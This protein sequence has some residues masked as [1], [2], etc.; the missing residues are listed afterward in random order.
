VHPTDPAFRDVADQE[1]PPGKP[2]VPQE[3]DQLIG[4]TGGGLFWDR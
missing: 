4:R 1:R 3:R 2:P